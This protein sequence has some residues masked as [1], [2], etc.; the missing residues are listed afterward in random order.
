M[1]YCLGVGYFSSEV[2]DLDI[3]H[4]KIIDQDSKQVAREA[5]EAIHIRI[6]NP[7][8]YHSM[9]KM[10]ILEICNNLLEADGSTNESNPLG[11]SDHSQSHIH[12]TIPSNRFAR[13][14]CLANYV[15]LVLLLWHLSQ[16]LIAT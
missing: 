14:V 7:T 3:S 4:F 9:G 15:A 10:Y 2:V 6:N 8:L 13:G 16:S 1:S 5:R 11:D 12:L